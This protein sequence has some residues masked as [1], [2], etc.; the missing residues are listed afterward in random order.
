MALPNIISEINTIKSTY[1][2]KS[3]GTITGSISGKSGMLFGTTDTLDIYICGGT[4]SSNNSF[5]QL[6]GG[7]H[8]DNA[9]QIFISPCISSSNKC[10]WTLKPDA[11][12]VCSS[13]NSSIAVSK[14]VLGD[15]TITNGFIK[16]A[17]GSSVGAHLYSG[18][19]NFDGATLQLYSRAHGSYPGHFYLRASSKSSSGDTAGT[20][21]DIV[22]KPDGTLTWGGKP[23]ICVTKWKSGTQWYRKYSDGWIEQGGQTPRTSDNYISI[24]FPIAFTQDNPNVQ[25]TRRFYYDND[26]TASQNRTTGVS[27]V[28]KTGF[29]CYDNGWS[30]NGYGTAGVWF[31][32]GF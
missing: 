24:S 26:G 25:L 7:Q 21:Y 15:F 5:I 14:L 11:S 23:I 4:K 8:P 16:G 30:A 12:I 18:A 1:L 6:N 27:S 28:T 32:C 2:P 13:T 29:K 17:G 20:S 10:V 22:G 19:N 3:G 31:A 9:G